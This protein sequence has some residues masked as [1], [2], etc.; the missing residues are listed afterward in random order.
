MLVLTSLNSEQYAAATSI[1]GPL[2]V[3]A[4]AGT[5][6]TRVITYR[7]AYMLNCGIQPEQIVA[8]S[9]TNK[10]SKEMTER[11][12]E[13][14]GAR[15]KTVWLGT[16]H[17]FCLSILR[18]FPA[19]A[20]LAPR[21]SI[22]DVGDQVDLVRK[23]LEE[24]KWNGLYQAEQLHSQ[25]SAAKNSLLSPEDIA[26]G[27][28]RIP[29][30]TDISVLSAV[31]SLYERQLL[32]N[33]V[34]DFDDCIYKTVRLLKNNTAIRERL[35]KEYQYMMVDEFQDTNS[36]QLAIMEM[37]GGR[38]KNVCVVGDDDQ[39]IYSWRGAM[40]EILEK[41][42]ESFPGTKMIKLEQ[43]YR[44]SNVILNAAN[45]VITNNTRRK[46]KVLWSES[47]ENAPIEILNCEDDSKESA[48]VTEKC[49]SLMGA[50]AAPKDIAVLYRANNLARQIEL[51][52]K[53]ARIPYKTYGGQSFFER[54]EVKDFI[55]Y[56]RLILNPAD[57]MALWRIINT[58][59]RGI[60]LKTLEKIEEFAH[61]RQKP[62]STVLT[63]PELLA[64]VRTDAVQGFAD[65][66][67][68]YRALPLNSAQDAEDL[69]R[70][71]LKSSGMENEIRCKTDNVA[72]RERKLENLRGLP[73]WISTIVGDHIANHGYVD[74]QALLDSLS[75]D[76]DKKEDQK[77][78][79]N[80]VSLMTIHAAKGLEFPHVFVVGVEEDILPHK[81]SVANPAAVCEERRLFYVALTRAKIN[82]YL[83][84]CLER[85]VANQ[86][87]Y[88][89][90][91]RFIEELPKETYL[92]GQELMRAKASTTEGR[93][94][95]TVARLGQLRALL[96]PT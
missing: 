62:P 51:G 7:I 96:K 89:R 69:C 66:I 14:V 72:V 52:L 28:H 92:A 64:S 19:E 74:Y 15:A 34:I 23:A 40:Y 50:G 65:L 3:L 47:K 53:E 36:A 30:S 5:G 93:K 48:F 21:F 43:N 31:Y 57:H 80:H 37:I 63:D 46:D 77:G 86:K 33:R 9:F 20:G 82:V 73:N 6:K 11:V 1:D 90:P 81:N 55:S 45:K 79:K 54:K 85:K 29:D 39:S 83:S 24:N 84:W 56:L 12:K 76:N 42:E 68:S 58:P 10:A 18:R 71:I 59:N 61:K 17:S 38:H 88:K 26:S 49:L 2:M 4:G 70:K 91:S 32:L 27:S 60:G 75:L 95:K 87:L 41:F 44:C 16:F 67:E 35:E 22:A 13:L 25:I 78:E 8:L 94:E